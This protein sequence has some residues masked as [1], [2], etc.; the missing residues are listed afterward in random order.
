MRA[1][2][3]AHVTVI[4][5]ARRRRAGGGAARGRRGGAARRAVRVPVGLVAGA[6]PD[7]AQRPAAS[8]RLDRPLRDRGA[9]RRAPGRRGD[10]RRRARGRHRLV[11]A[12]V[13][14]AGG[15][16]LAIVGV[17]ALA[18]PTRGRLGAP[19]QAGQLTPAPPRPASGSGPVVAVPLRL[20]DPEARRGLRATAAPPSRRSA[21]RRL[22]RGARR[23]SPTTRG[24][25]GDPAGLDAPRAARRR[26]HARH[27]RSAAA[28]SP[29]GAGS[30]CCARSASRPRGVTGVL[31]GHYLALAV[32]AAPFGL[33]GGPRCSRRRC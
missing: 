5:P 9:A 17:G 13:P 24:D 14:A 7:R 31:V 30:A 6:R 10:A 29:T 33:L 3:G 2:N 26:L 25:A 18:L 11:P 1:T 22:A 32:L 28:C 16:R 21:G 27:R 4:G 8:A 19:A 23:T 12:T 20:R 15:V